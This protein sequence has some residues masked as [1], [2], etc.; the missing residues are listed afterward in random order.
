MTAR[1]LRVLF[2][3]LFLWVFGFGLYDEFLPI[4]A[5]AL[6]A[7]GVQ[8]GL[9]FT[10]RQLTITVGSVLGGVLADRFSRRTVLLVAWVLGAPSPLLF[11]PARGWAALLP[12]ILLYDITIFALPALN[13]YVAERT[14]PRKVASTFAV[15]TMASGLS[16]LLSP[17]LGGLIAARWGIPTTFALAFVCYAASTALIFWSEPER[18]GG[19]AALPWRQALRI[20]DFGHLWPLFI[21]LGLMTGIPLALAPFIPPFLREV[22][23]LGLA[24]IGLLGSILSG[25]GLL[26]TLLTGRLADRWGHRPL[27][28]L[29]LLL[30]GGG[31]L[32]VALGPVALL[33]LAFAIKSRSA[34]QALSQAVVAARISTEAAGRG[35]GLLG[36]ITGLAGAGGTM[37]AGIGYRLDPALPLLVGGAAV[38]ALAAAL[39]L[40]KPGSGREYD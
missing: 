39:M 17:A 35:F 7:T 29:T 4:H 3:S 20:W 12:G 23:G 28:V 36:M 6:G 32:I 13:A 11:L 15:L 21:L 38:A 22:R 5:R 27:L 2:L 1:N 34:A 25:G 18:P 26:F 9:L 14:D 37:L 16:L 30:I 31:N 8:L 40:Q 33:P 10:I 24:Q 19:R